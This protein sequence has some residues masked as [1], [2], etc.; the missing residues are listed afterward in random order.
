MLKLRNKVVLAVLLLTGAALSATAMAQ[1]DGGDTAPNPECAPGVA[2]PQGPG[3]ND[4]NP[5]KDRPFYIEKDSPS[6]DSYRTL[7]RTGKTKQANLVYK[8]AR[9]PR[10]LWYGTFTRPPHQ[11]SLKIRKPIDKADAECALPLLTVL[12][13]ESN[14]CHARYD[15]GGPAEDA[16]TREW[17]DRFANVIGDSRVVIAFEPDSLGTI[18]CHAK[19]RRDDRIA[20]LRYGVDV[21]SKLPN[22]TIYIEA[23]A[24]DWTPA[25]QIA[26]LLRQV[27]VAKVRGFMLNATHYDWT[28]ANIR[29]GLDVSRR[30]GGKHFVINT[31][32][33]GR[34]PVHYRRG[35]RRINVWCDPGLRGLGPPPTTNT[36]NAKVD[37]YLWINRP[38]FQQSCAGHKIAWNLPRALTYARFAT[39]WESPPRGTRLGHRKRY[40]L[41]AFTKGR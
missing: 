27:G 32:E 24:S 11:F 14:Q 35:H 26:S 40:P 29:F 15:G 10:N 6:W 12:R 8:I 31:A 3:A 28:S 23:A 33:N 9:E 25:G 17:Y 41:R 19:S 36:S 39:T 21:L 30:I 37:A 7:L 2:N 13:A 20:L 34:G 5:L 18:R 16:R 22:A 1:R 38:G 4:P